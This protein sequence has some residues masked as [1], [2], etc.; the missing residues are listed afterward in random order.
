MSESSGSNGI[1]EVPTLGLLARKVG[2]FKSE[3][4]SMSLNHLILYTPELY[5]NLISYAWDFYQS[6]CNINQYAK[7]S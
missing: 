6:V 3:Y 5:T 7:L 1:M 4:L 2:R